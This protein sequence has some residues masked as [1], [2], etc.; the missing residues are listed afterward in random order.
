MNAEDDGLICPDVGSWAE[1]KYRLLALYDELFSTG[2]KYKWDQRVYIDLY[3]SAGY[4]RV[5]GTKKILKGSPV[6]ALGVTHLFDKYVFCEESSDLLE[7]LTVRATRIAPQAQ[8][9]YIS[10]TCDTKSPRSAKKF[11]RDRQ[12][13]RC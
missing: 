6:L 10:G 12:T 3:S 13:T 11:P 5:R 7:A 4:A 1:T 8:V 9:A 2:M